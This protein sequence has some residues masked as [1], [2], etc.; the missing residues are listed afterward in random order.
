MSR[1]RLTGLAAALAAATTTL[2]P[3]AVPPAWAQPAADV[4]GWISVV[5]R[6]PDGMDRAE[7]KEKR[8]EAARKL[9]ASRDKRAVP[10]LI[11]L[12]ESETFDI[13]GEIAIDG[14]GALG[15]A[16]AVAALQRIAADNARDRAQRDLARKALAKLG[17][18]ADGG[19]GGGG[20][21]GDPGLGRPGD[22]DGDGVAVST[23]GATTTTTTTT[24]DPATGGGGASSSGGAT[25]R[26]TTPPTLSDDTLAAYERIT[27]AAGAANLSFDT[28]RDEAS[29][30]ADLAGRY[31]RR[32]ERQTMAWGVD[33][34]ARL[35]TGY[36]NPEGDLSA[37][38]A[39]LNVDGQG[40]ARFYSGKVYGIGRL[41]AQGVITYIS[42]ENVVDVRNAVD[43]E[44]ALGAGYGR[45]LDV[46]ASLRVKRIAAALEAARALG[47]PIDASLA[48]KLQLAWWSLRGS[49]SLHP[50]LTRTVAILREAGVLLGEPDA[51]LTYELLQVLG[52]GLLDR[53]HSG[54]DAYLA[55]GEGYLLREDDPQVDEGRV[56]QL[57][58]RA[59][60][61]TQLPGNTA[62]VSGEGY[63]R[64]RLFVAEGQPSPWALGATARWRKF[65]YTDHFDPVGAIDVAASLAVSDD[66]G[67][68]SE[69]AF[70]V[71]GEVGFTF[72]PNRASALR[73]AASASF[74]SGEL[75]VGASLGA[76]YGLADG[77]VSGL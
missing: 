44:L 43:L 69:M 38:G 33:A 34:G 48:N 14:L 70:R 3:P 18:S 7:W 59:A 15:D 49:R 40:E 39:L 37:R 77:S 64:L 23:G 8:R 12:A 9:G 35:V 25:D 62:E 57:L 66:G 19:G 1:L 63:A 50:L 16:S 53:R 17:A 4:P 36:Y 30:D 54:V 47:R 68:M 76:R 32:L 45:V 71:G 75:I 41:A 46:G 67:D 6:Q 24:P 13:I 29:F 31:Q 73:L 60:Y 72:V 42:S 55:F 65:T 28:L 74:D 52:D 56:E 11:K 58:A 27:L 21:D 20:G 2:A 22:G 61:A 5:E 26:P 10:V 51:G